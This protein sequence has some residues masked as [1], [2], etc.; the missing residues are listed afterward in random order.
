MQIV[1]L[2]TDRVWLAVAERGVLVGGVDDI[3]GE[4][5]SRRLEAVAAGELGEADDLVE[6]AT[7]VRLT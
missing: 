4:L 2:T 7:W 6:A 5:E 1:E 3:I